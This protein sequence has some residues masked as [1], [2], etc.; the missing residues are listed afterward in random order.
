[1]NVCMST[2]Y[3]DFRNAGIGRV[4]SAIADGM[5]KRGHNVHRISTDRT[6]L[7]SYFKYTFL[8]LKYKIPKGYDVYHA[9]TP[10]EGMW[11]PSQKT[12]VT[13]YDLIP[14][15]HLNRTGSGI[16]NSKWKRL[17]GS[18]AFEM[19]CKR[20]SKAARIACISRDT[21]K[22]VVKTFD[23]PYKKCSVIRLGIREDLEPAKKPD[24]VFRIGYLGQLDRRKRVNMLVKVFTESYF[25][26]ELVLAGGGA[27]EKEVKALARG[28]PRIRFLGYLPDDELVDFYN[29]ID[30]F[31]FPTWVEGYGLPPVEA[32]ACKKPTIVMMDAVMP[33]DVKSRCILTDDL[34]LII[35]NEKYLKGRMAS[36]DLEDNYRFAKEHSWDKCLDEYERLYKEVQSA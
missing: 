14:L 26:G 32:M 12:V 23:V 33:F 17:I 18:K 19:G 6:D 36:I 15:L 20:A 2:R 4:S 29:S 1:M 8:E 35:G 25:N 3:F 27:D 11:T 9:L 5:E 21:L 10:M 31:A 16:G 13:F 34:G 22:D 7:Y 28:D 24:N 30:V